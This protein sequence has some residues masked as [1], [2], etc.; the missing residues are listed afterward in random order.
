MQSWDR[1]PSLAR[2]VKQVLGKLGMAIYNLRGKYAQDGLLTVHSAAFRQ[3][4][5]F[6]DAYARG[7]R[8]SNGVDPGFEWRVHTALWAAQASLRVDGDFVECGVNA[9]FISSAIMRWLDWSRLGRRFYRLLRCLP[10]KTVTR[11]SCESST[12]WGAACATSPKRTTRLSTPSPLRSASSSTPTGPIERALH[13]QN[14]NC[15]LEYRT[16]QSPR[17][18]PRR[19]WHRPAPV[20]SERK[21]TQPH[22][23]LPHARRTYFSQ[24]SQGMTGLP[25]RPTS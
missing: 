13:G 14:R 3:D 23:H 20:R 18:R 19:R 25:I 15:R 10:Y 17:S 4:Q 6:K 16:R 12:G 11:S 22:R 21:N 5:R 2:S 9:G 24:V 7:V 1:T 8:A